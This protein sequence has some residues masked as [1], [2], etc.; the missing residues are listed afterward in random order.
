MTPQLEAR[1]RQLRAEGLSLRAIAAQVSTP[2][3]G[4][5]YVTVAALFRAEAA[6]P[7]QDTLPLEAAEPPASAPPAVETGAAAPAR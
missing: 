6:Q 5:S 7:Q 1:C 4:I 2:S 3:K